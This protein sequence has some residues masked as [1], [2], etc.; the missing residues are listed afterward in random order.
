MKRT[1]F[2]LAFWVSTNIVFAQTISLIEYYVDTDPGYGL[3]KSVSTTP[4][5]TVSNFTFPAD[6]TGTS[7]G[8]HR[9]YVR[10]KDSN[11]SWSLLN[12]ILFLQD[13]AIVQPESKVNRIEY[14]IDTD[15]GYGLGKPISFSQSANVSNI[16]YVVDISL[17]SN[18]IHQ[19][20]V[21]AKDANGRWSILNNVTFLQETVV[22]PTIATVTH[23]EY[24]LDTDPGYG[25]GANIPFTPSADV[26]NLNFAADI[27]KSSVGTH[28]MYIRAKDSKGN[29]S[30]LNIVNFTKVITGGI[31]KTELNESFQAYPNP[32]TGLFEVN[33][34]FQT[35]VVRN[36]SGA[37]VLNK[38]ANNSQF[39]D[40]RNQSKGTY[41]AE[42]KSG[43]KTLI[44]KL[45]LE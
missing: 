1:L 42:I 19:L 18:G 8:I 12:N 24:Y 30:L 26:K 45:V 25:M 17:V 22:T 5:S 11:G 27:S 40:L 41:F 10:A 43:D 7:N 39:I 21:R 38:T 15:P 34:P 6:I 9:L 29:W 23:I 28:V 20:F 2:L 3:G 16:N 4:S 36:T 14:F 37:I 35:I 31:E 13:V 44:Q 33:I 32:S